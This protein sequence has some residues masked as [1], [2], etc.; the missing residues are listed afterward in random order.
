MA[1][2]DIVVY[3]DNLTPA[4]LTPTPTTIVGKYDVRLS[5][6]I[7]GKYNVNRDTTL[8]SLYDVCLASTIT[9]KYSILPK[10]GD[11]SFR[12]AWSNY[13]IEIFDPILTEG[14]FNN[15]K[16][17]QRLGQIPICTFDVV[18]PSATIISQLI[19][20]APIRI[21]INGKLLFTGVLKRIEKDD[22]I[23]IYHL[24]CEG[25]ASIL[26]DINIVDKTEYSHY[27]SY[28]IIDDLLQ[29]ATN[30]Y[31]FTSN[32]HYIDYVVTPGPALNHIVNICKM[33][34][35]DWEVRQQ[36]TTRVISS[37]TATASTMVVDGETITNDYY[38]GRYGAYVNGASADTGFQ[39]TANT[40]N[41]LT[42]ST[43]PTSVATGDQV[44][45][46]GKYIF[47]ADVPSTTSATVAH[48]VINKNCCKLNRKKNVDKVVTSVVGVGQNPEVARMV[49][50]A[51]ACTLNF[52]TLDSYESCLTQ[53]INTTDT[54]LSLYN[55]TD[56]ASNGIIMIGDE[57][58]LYT[59]K[60]ATGFGPCTRA[61]DSTTAT[62]HYVGDDVLMVNDLLFTSIP[63]TFPDTGSFWLGTE[64]IDYT[65]KDTYRFYNLTRGASGTN[66]YRHSDGAIAFDFSYSDANPEVGCSVGLYGI[67]QKTISVVG[68]TIRDTIDH[69]VQNELLSNDDLIEYGDFTLLSADYWYNV[70]LG[71]RFKFTDKSGTDNYWTIIG[72]DHEQYRPLVIYFGRS[73]DNITEDFAKIDIIDTTAREK[74]EPSRK[75]T[76]Q[77]MSSDK[78][79]ARVTFSDGTSKWVDLV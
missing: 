63:T 51:T 69:R 36:N 24:M 22:N 73:E 67:Q 38:A 35:F 74:T 65:S 68:A 33:E 32:W 42:V 71:D 11:S 62:Y 46:W 12:G 13:V 23:N 1:K 29:P 7:I 78:K 4:S 16:V 70:N 55:T 64:L 44:I 56:Y 76:I 60:S 15:L 25:G 28:Y 6:S 3:L 50:W 2:Y 53:T 8:D 41:T 59:N 5:D 52:A 61:Y 30:W 43:I 9:G 45:L 34:G 21:R 18:N 10:H 48:Y 79:H 66:K 20:N 26:R 17:R 54:W 49:S 31:N 14:Q 27:G 75:A 19:Y 77:E 39:I 58:I 57:K 40:G 72:S 37:Y 47:D